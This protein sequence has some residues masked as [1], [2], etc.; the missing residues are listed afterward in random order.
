[1]STASVG[2]SILFVKTSILLQ[3]RKMSKID[4]MRSSIDYREILRILQKASTLREN[5]IWQS[6]ALGKNII[7][8]HHFEIDF[9]AREVVVYFD[10]RRFILDQD[11]PLYVKLDYR[12]SVFKVETFRL[13]QESVHF[14]FPK[15]MKTEELRGHARHT[16][17]PNL[18]K[19]V[20]LRSAMT[21][22]PFEPGNE[23]RARAIDV[24]REGLGLLLSENNRSYLKNNRLLWITRLDED[25]LEYPLL[26]EV[27]YINN[28]IDLRYL[29]RKQRELK[30]GLKLSGS[31]SDEIYN[32]FI[33]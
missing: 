20:H 13:S 6:H 28:D 10:T 33:G 26:C 17:P 16:F 21:G 30:V 14:S 7:P 23:M 11:L 1:M 5:L 3:S 15:E 24:S 27:V 19:F 32:K 29:V 12:T 22:S 9:V 2:A 8:V 31:F 4:K 18:D 25:A